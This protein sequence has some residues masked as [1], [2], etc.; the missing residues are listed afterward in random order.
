MSCNYFLA[1]TVTY[2]TRENASVVLVFKAC[3]SSS[4]F[5]YLL[6]LQTKWPLASILTG[7]KLKNLH[8]IISY[9]VFYSHKVHFT[10]LFTVDTPLLLSTP[11]SYCRQCFQRWP[12]LEVRMASS[13]CLWF[14]SSSWR[15]EQEYRGKGGSEMNTPGHSLTKCIGSWQPHNHTTGGGYYLASPTSQS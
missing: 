9:S 12:V 14:L 2:V 3:A 6:V 10:K 13:H 5:P 7:A 15:E 8:P 11:T 4:T 1:I